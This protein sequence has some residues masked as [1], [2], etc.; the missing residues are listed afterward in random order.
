MENTPQTETW[1]DERIGGRVLR[2]WIRDKTVPVHR[3]SIW[4]YFG[5]MT[6]FLFG[7]Q[8]VTG[9]LLLLYYRPT[10]ESAFESVQFIMA[11]V[12]FGW[13]IR[14]I[15]SWS[16]NLMILVLF[17]HLASVYLTKAYRKP[18]EMT[19]IS[20]VFLLLLSLGFGFSGY[21]LPWNKLAFFATQVGT[22]IAGAVPL[23]GDFLVKFLRGGEQVT[24]ATLTRFFGFHVA[25][26]PA[27]TTLFLG[28][29]ILLVQLHGMSVPEGEHPQR[30]MPFYPNFLLRDLLGWL[31]AL[32][33][34]AA[35]AALFPWELGEKA[36]P[37]A[38]APQGIRPEWFFVWMFQ[39]LKVFPANLW[40]FEGEQI[41]IVVFSL[42]GLL[43]LAVPF[44]D[45][46][47]GRRRVSRFF[48]ILGWLFLIYFL[49]A[50]GS[51]YAASPQQ[52]AGKDTCIDCHRTLDG[53]AKQAV[54]IFQGDIHRERGLSCADCHGGDPARGE[55]GDM[56]AAMDTARGYIGVPR[57]SEMAGFCGRCHSDLN[58][59]RRFNPQARVDQAA[60]YR[61]SVHGIRNAQGDTKAATCV[62]CHSVHEI[63][64]VRDSTAP[65]YPSH[66][67]QTCAKCHA[68]ADYM[69]PYKIP[70]D[71]FEKYGKSIHSEFLIGRRELSAPTCNDC[72]GNHGAQPPGTES[73][74]AVCGQCHRQE[75]TLFAASPHQRPF[76]ELSL[77]ACITCHDNHETAA[78]DDRLLSVFGTGVC[79]NCHSDG[80]DVAPKIL[81]MQKSILGL[82][83][84]IDT[85][86]EVLGRAQ[87]AGMEVSRA[88]FGLQEAADVLIKARVSVHGFN[89]EE[90]ETKVEPAMKIAVQANTDGLNAL[91]E[92]NVRRRGLGYSL[93][94]IGIAIAA[95]L[96][97]IRE[98]DRRANL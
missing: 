10:A 65:V 50:T 25:V 61:T 46:Q 5:G 4:Y 79:A 64:S 45:T 93:I 39:T 73:V 70:V 63:K 18:R 96:I 74:A 98:I 55:D 27:L 35:L 37:F 77:P 36:D 12:P 41:A 21:L 9:I 1:L 88:A 95:L 40:I 30:R 16:A 66:V 86:A 58:Y 57:P 17:I 33:S 38:A 3:H 48:S 29:H 89:P 43:L 97:K 59:M 47:T 42:I 22:E 94:A 75:N 51:A 83:L 56:F 31:V 34:L 52:E 23:I 14:S 49:L 91:E 2:H 54:D 24:G 84:Q 78:A 32:A 20:G 13:L 72:H 69:A 80:D 76:A 19:W 53:P 7:M 60:E 28:V 26:L 71:Q 82:R 15:H 92:V 90:I 6:L 11:E 85:A 87:R 44:L 62:S 68:D 67:A 81:R 8:A